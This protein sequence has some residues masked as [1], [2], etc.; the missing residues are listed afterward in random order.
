MG[1]PSRSPLLVVG[2]PL[3]I[4]ELKRPRVS[5]INFEVASHLSVNVVTVPLLHGID[6]PT[7]DNPLLWFAFCHDG[8]L[9]IREE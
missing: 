4:G 7:A 6:E 9:S 8:T 1:L 2:L 5:D 3:N